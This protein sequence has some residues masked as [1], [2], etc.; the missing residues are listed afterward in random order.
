MISKHDLDEQS[1]QESH[2]EPEDT[3]VLS[4]PE[5]AV[6]LEYH[7]CLPLDYQAHSHVSR[8]QQSDSSEDLA[9]NPLRDG[10][11]TPFA[12]STVDPSFSGQ[13]PPIERSSSLEVHASSPVPLE[14]DLSE[15]S[16][17]PL[18]E[19]LENKQIL[20]TDGAASSIGEERVFPTQSYASVYPFSET[21]SESGSYIVVTPRTSH[22]E[23]K[24]SAYPSPRYSEVQ[25][26]NNS[27]V[28][29]PSPH[30]AT[31]DEAFDDQFSYLRTTHPLA[32]S[33]NSAPPTFCGLSTPN[34][35]AIYPTNHASEKLRRPPYGDGL[36]YPP[37]RTTEDG[38]LI[39]PSVPGELPG[40]ISKEPT[41]NEYPTRS[42]RSNNP[43]DQFAVA[44]LS[45]NVTAYRKGKYPR[46]K[47]YSSYRQYMPQ[48]PFDG[49]QT[50]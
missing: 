16:T 33:Y 4:L 43:D 46:R 27:T 24:S 3:P 1:S 32:T 34:S 6:G 30:L 40:E 18:D 7:A 48:P 39:V 37:C 23:T 28:F 38:L 14:K 17:L 11:L 45:P 29:I 5:P 10:Q 44:P 26:L 13:R 20:G 12:S 9:G 47:R 49:N 35:P 22:A 21:T 25:Q 19:D 36:K 15:L 50:M 2:A 31:I 41:R 42:E 8:E